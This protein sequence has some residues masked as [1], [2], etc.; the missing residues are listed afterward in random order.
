MV[1]RDEYRERLSDLPEVGIEAEVAR[2]FDGPSAQVIL[3]MT[4]F[5]DLP[6]G[7]RITEGDVKRGMTLGPTIYIEDEDPSGAAMFAEQ[8]L[9]ARVRRFV[10]SMIRRSFGTRSSNS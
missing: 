2:M 3:T 1:T 5:V 10:G 7:R 4:L 6:D 9:E 8:S